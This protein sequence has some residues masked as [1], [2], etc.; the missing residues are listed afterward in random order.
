MRKSEIADLM[1][2]M[3]LDDARNALGQ[4]RTFS[5]H[6]DDEDEVTLHRLAREVEMVSHVLAE[7]GQRL[8]DRLRPPVEE[9]PT[10]KT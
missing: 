2:S 5:E 4:A 7:L 6:V 10:R 9:A 1:A 8:E 3:R